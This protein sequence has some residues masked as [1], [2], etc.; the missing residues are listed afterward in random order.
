MRRDAAGH[1]KTWGISTGGTADDATRAAFWEPSL[2]ER[3]R[4]KRV[5][6]I[7]VGENMVKLLLLF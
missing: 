7:N 1:W 6:M 3:K 5:A 2:V 4:A